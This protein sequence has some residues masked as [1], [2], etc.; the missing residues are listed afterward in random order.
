MLHTALEFLKGSCGFWILS[1]VCRVILRIL[2]LANCFAVGSFE[3]WISYP[4]YVMGSQGSWI[5]SSGFAVG[6]CGSWILFFG[7]GTC[8]TPMRLG[9]SVQKFK[10]HFSP[11]TLCILLHLL[12]WENVS[13]ALNPAGFTAFDKFLKTVLM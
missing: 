6:S 5:L 7:H 10:T 8:L 2:D 3:S 9:Q 4:G 11:A 12:S 1:T 13:K